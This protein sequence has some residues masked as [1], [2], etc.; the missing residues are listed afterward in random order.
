MMIRLSQFNKIES[1]GYMKLWSNWALSY[2]IY[3]C[4]ILFLVLAI[5]IQLTLKTKTNQNR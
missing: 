3:P 1:F 2:D 4:P 5:I